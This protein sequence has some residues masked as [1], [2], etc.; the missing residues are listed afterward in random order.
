MFDHERTRG[1]VSI[2]LVLA[3]GLMILAGASLGLL[4]LVE[5]EGTPI[6]LT[7]GSI[8]NVLFA[9]VLVA[10]GVETIRRRHFL[11]AFVVPAVLAFLNLAY[12]I[13]TG[14]PSLV[15][16]VVIMILVVVMI[17]SQRSDFV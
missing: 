9:L 3:G 15:T 12:L 17:G 2:G 8:A 1:R 7:V 4:V 11:F 10:S 16:G 6:S 14:Q 13:Q 5:P